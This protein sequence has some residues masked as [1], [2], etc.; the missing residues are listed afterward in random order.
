MREIFYLSESGD[1]V[2]WKNSSVGMLFGW[3]I[4]H[5]YFQENP[6]TVL[7][8]TEEHTP[9]FVFEVTKDTISRDAIKAWNKYNQYI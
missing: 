6:G 9:G 7:K 5:R 2:L 1:A 3:L 8:L 4:E